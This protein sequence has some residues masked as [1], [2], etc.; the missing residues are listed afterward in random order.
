MRVSRT[1]ALT[2]A[3]I[4]ILSLSIW[5]GILISPANGAQLLKNGSF[6]QGTDQWT[7]TG[8]TTAG[9]PAISGTA[10]GLN[11]VP[12]GALISQ[13][14]EVTPGEYSLK[15]HARTIDGKPA[16]LSGRVSWV[17][18]GISRSHSLA[19]ATMGATYQLRTASTFNIAAPTTLTVRFSVLANAPT[20]VCL[21]DA[22][23]D[24]PFNVPTATSTPSS[25]AS[26]TSTAT[27]TST[28]TPTATSTPTITSTPNPPTATKTAAPG[29]TA[30][31]AISTPPAAARTMRFI[32]GGFEDGLDGWDNFGGEIRTVS[33]PKL[34]GGAAGRL[35]SA[36]DST[37]RAYQVVAIDAVQSYEFKGSLQTD[38]GASEAFLRIAWY[39]SG[40][41][42]G[43]QLETIDSTSKIGRSAGFTFLST[44]P[45]MPPPNARSAQVRVVLIP[46]GAAPAAVYMDDLSFTSGPPVTATATPKPAT[47]T[48]QAAKTA[49]AQAGGPPSGDD[50]GDDDSE[51]APHSEV[52]G[53]Q[54]TAASARSAQTN[55]KATSTPRNRST[56]GQPVADPVTSS[57]DG[58]LPAWSYV[59]VPLVAMALAGGLWYGKRREGD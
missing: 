50:R 26:P 1:A 36:T 54:G 24:G 20:V 6:D 58:L 17:T 43:S 33:S 25:T 51:D 52:A 57:D 21:D 59:A 3:A 31:A 8:L 56:D 19:S 49:T 39:A 32:N 45:V 18:D 46:S 22:S 10:L 44:G 48:A 27:S 4:L 13:Q 28:N 2:S 15:V 55:A 42:S 14:V 41:G 38:G 7:V 11:A 23:L 47:A 12:D 29:S 5:S 16:T 35:S 30:T 37:K 53:V 40:D 34:S 9:C